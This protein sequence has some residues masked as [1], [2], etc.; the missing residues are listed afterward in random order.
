MSRDDDAAVDDAQLGGA[1]AVGGDGGGQPHHLAL[2]GEGGA[3][4][5]RGDGDLGVGQTGEFFMLNLHPL[6][7]Q[8]NQCVGEVAGR[9]SGVGEQHQPGGGV[10]G[11]GEAGG[12]QGGPQVGAGA[13]AVVAG[14][15]FPAVERFGDGLGAVAVTQGAADG[16]EGV[17][18]AGVEGGDDRV[19]VGE[20]AAGVGQ[21][22]RGGKVEH[23]DGVQAIDGAVDG[24][25]REGEGEQHDGKQTQ[26]EAGVA[27]DGGAVREGLEQA[28]SEQGRGGEDEPQG[29]GFGELQ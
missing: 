19:D 26:R 27:L 2:V 20:G 29:P 9:G 10:V 15:G 1:G 21:I 22:D 6:V 5:E 25:P 14:A 23:E 12:P 13:E 8:L 3:G 28:P 16:E 11:D 24:G 18:V 4:A 7:L 17:G